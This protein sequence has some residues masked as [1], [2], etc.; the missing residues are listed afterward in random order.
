MVCHGK[1]E[2]MAQ[3]AIV[4]FIFFAG[5]GIPNP[6]WAEPAADPRALGPQLSMPLNVFYVGT[7]DI[8]NVA[9]LPNVNPQAGLRFL[10][11]K[12][13][14]VASLAL[15]QPQSEIDR[16]GRTRGQSFVLSSF[17]DRYA[18]DVYYQRFQGL[19]M[20]RV[21]GE[22]DRNKADRFPQL[23]DAR[24]ETWGFNF[25]R[26]WGEDP[27]N[28][29]SAF[30]WLDRSSPSAGAWVISPFYNRLEVSL[31]EILIPA[32]RAD[33]PSEIPRLTSGQFHTAGASLGYAH[34]WRWG[35]RWFT[36]LHAG[37][38]PAG[39]LAFF[40]RP[41]RDRLARLGVAGKINGYL[42]LGYRGESFQAG[43]RGMADS[44][45]SD[46]QGKYMAH[47]LFVGSLYYLQEI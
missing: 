37:L 8:N 36:A 38:G 33:Y 32:S 39:Q 10:W 25:H 18:L 29:R 14:L 24:L 1:S 21:I 7:P 31:G 41:G 26:T 9:L 6:G 16:R 43:F 2:L 35:T 44:L 40:E 12:Y 17:S 20:T 34:L 11:R 28:L 19:Y 23:P 27:F 5:P 13:G 22:L 42:A 47:S 4:L 45:S 15:P 30:D 46:A 3:L